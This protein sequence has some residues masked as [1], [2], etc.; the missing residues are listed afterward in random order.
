LYL[1]VV[2]LGISPFLILLFISSYAKLYQKTPSLLYLSRKPKS[3][4]NMHK[5]VIAVRKDLKLD[6]GKLAVQVAHASLD[7]YKKASPQ[8]REEWESEGSKKVVVKAEGLKELLDLQKKAR[9]LGLPFSLIRDAGRT[10]LKPGTITCLGIGPAPESD[11]D[12]VTGK[13][14]IL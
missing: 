5:Q 3:K 6:K 8:A 1:F 7:S 14:K 13:L 2:G 11:I 4:A 12:K 9:L 10:H